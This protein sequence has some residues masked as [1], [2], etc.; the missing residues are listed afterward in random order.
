LSK[1]LDLWNF[2]ISFYFRGIPKTWRHEHGDLEMK[3]WR[4]GDGDMETWNHRNM[5]NY[6]LR[7]EDM[8]GDMETWNH[9]NMEK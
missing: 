5:E 2:G 4:H 3:T 9:G 6:T 8:D 1:E 7:N